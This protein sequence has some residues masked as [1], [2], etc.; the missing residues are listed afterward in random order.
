MKIIKIQSFPDNNQSSINNRNTTQSNL[1]TQSSAIYKGLNTQP[2]FQGVGSRLLRVINRFST[3][4]PTEIAAISA[5]AKTDSGSYA[6]TKKG[7]RPISR[8]RF[9]ALSK[10]RDVAEVII[11]HPPRKSRPE[12]GKPSIA[13]Q[14]G[15][16]PSSVV[17]AI[18]MRIKKMTFVTGNELHVLT[19]P[20]RNLDD[21][22]DA[23]DTSHHIYAE[24]YTPIPPQE[25]AVALFNRTLGMLEETSA[26]N[27]GIKLEKFPLN[28]V[29]QN[30]A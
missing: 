24:M 2:S 16:A 26:K 21:I 12:T 27:H 19:L 4:I 11:K 8:R 15:V 1:C 3:T 28:D 23:F 7:Y 20:E 17:D 25:R 22:L 18:K 10:K 9:L 29:L 5:L 30:A 13:V 6:L 14:E